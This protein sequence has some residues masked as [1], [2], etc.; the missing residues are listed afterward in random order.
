YACGAGCEKHEERVGP[1]KTDAVRAYHDRRARAHS[2]PGWCP[3]V[4]RREA[5]ERA[6]QEQARQRC[7][8]TFG[9]YADDYQTW[10]EQ[11]DATGQVR[12]RSWRTIKAELSRLRPAFGEK[13]LDNITTAGIER[14]L[15][16]L[17]SEVSQA[18]ANRYRDRLSGMFKRAIRL[19]LMTT[20][21]VASVPK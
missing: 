4:E 6:R 18:T 19:G 17:L 5:R 1:L 16:S 20:N 7:R 8:I 15:E 14:F 12:K 21:P 3:A 10:C 2:E 9:E 13:L 11:T